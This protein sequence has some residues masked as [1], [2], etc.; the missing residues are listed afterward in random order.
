MLFPSESVLVF[1]KKNS[2][3]IARPRSGRSNLA[4]RDCLPDCSKISS[5]QAGFVGLRPPR[6]DVLLAITV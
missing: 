4:F 6:N 1:R 3:V 2:S 5:G